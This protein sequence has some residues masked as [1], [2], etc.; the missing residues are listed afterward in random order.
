MGIFNIG[1]LAAA[2]LA[3]AGLAACRAVLPAESRA[4]GNNAEQSSPA[5]A[6]TPTPTPPADPL[7]AQRNEIKKKLAAAGIAEIYHQAN[8]PDKTRGK[9][10]RVSGY[11]AGGPELA[12]DKG[13]PISGDLSS[14]MSRTIELLPDAHI[15]Y[16]VLDLICTPQ[17]KCPRPPI[18]GLVRGNSRLALSTANGQVVL[19][20]IA[21]GEKGAFDFLKKE[22]PSIPYPDVPPN[23]AAAAAAGKIQA[24]GKVYP[25]AKSKD[26]VIARLRQ[27]E[28]DTGRPP[29]KIAA[30]S[31]P[32]TKGVTITLAGKKI[33][34]PEDAF[35][36][37]N[38][39]DVVSPPGGPRIET[40]V[41]V[42]RRGNSTIS[43]SVPS[44]KVH[45]EKLAPGEEKAFDFLRKALQ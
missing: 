21:S 22:L 29:G 23:A 4:A 7:I 19:E 35:I 14:G 32:E 34:L 40:P 13:K 20:E 30:A 5:Q 42:L 18:I 16:T 10:I 17:K 27:W 43:I 12:R 1:L 28:K 6:V 31:G 41:L 44:G 37:H 24:P 2:V 15:E 11:S 8:N 39:V 33:K 9:P 3:G 36:E 45:E 25:P 26:E 38:I